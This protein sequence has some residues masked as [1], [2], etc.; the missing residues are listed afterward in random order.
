MKDKY[1][2]AAKKAAENN[3]SIWKVIGN[4][5]LKAAQIVCA[6]QTLPFTGIKPFF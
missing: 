5:L 1:E 2:E 4:G 3:G 6:P